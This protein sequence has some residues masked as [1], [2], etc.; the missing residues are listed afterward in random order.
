MAS[1]LSIRKAQV[2]MQDTCVWCDSVQDVNWYCND[3]Q[4]ALCDKC[5]DGHKRG[6]KTRND[7][8][9]PIKQANKTG[10]VVLPEV[11][12]IHSGKTRDLFCTECNVAICSMCFTTKHK[13]H[14]FKHFEDEI[15]TQTHYMREQLET[16]KFKL[17]QL[18]EKLSNRRKE[19][20]TFKESVDIICKDVKE[21]GTKLK[22][23]IDSLVDNVLAELSS[24]VAEE[25]KL[26]QQ[27]CEYEDENVKQIKQ[28]IEEVEQQSENPSS[29]TLFEL[30]RRL[31]TTIPLYDVTGT[32][33]PPRPFIFDTGQI[34]TE[35]LKN[36][37]GYV[38]MGS[39]NDSTP[40]YE[41]TEINNQHLRKLTTFQTPPNKS[42]VSVCPIDDI[43][44]WISM[45]R[46]MDLFQ[47]NKNGNVTETV[48][49]DFAPWSLA[50][51]NVGLLMT[52]NDHSTL[53]HKLS[54]IRRVTTFA[55]ISPLKAYS[56]SV[57]D[58][59]EVFVST[60][61][62]TILVLNMSGDKVRQL[63][64][65]QG[66]SRIASLTGGNVAVTTGGV[67]CKELN[68]INKSGQ[69]IYTWSGK[70]ASGQTLSR[71]SQNSIAC[72]KYDRVFVPDLDTHQVYVISR[73]EKKAKC[74][75]N[76][77]HGILHPMA[78]G[79]DRCGHV[80][81]GCNDGTVHVI[82]L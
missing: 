71:T 45:Y 39:K 48:K 67:N 30:T 66:G 33:V 24:L 37:I 35:Q 49:L 7:D 32:S 51:T 11:C 20:T 42:I 17:D 72:D 36:M 43:Y 34:N 8:V 54:E 68:I 40:M 13:Q 57:S 16:L 47:V 46:Y 73:N 3:C 29:G 63:S 9:V 31:R 61:T 10:Q 25:D 74:I 18:N 38:Q 76:R 5:K 75:L 50:L 81:I 62:T 6:K 53:I 82:Q 77:K 58:T 23:E 26:L 59:D 56:I 65:G 44:A 64:Y 55:D 27:D 69:I 41:K 21:Q 52:R 60:D 14:A 28:L 70:Q 15:N 80:W 4:E 19:S 2:H 78:V 22:A 12:K 1:K 79:V